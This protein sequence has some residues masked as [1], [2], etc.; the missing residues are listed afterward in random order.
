VSPTPAKEDADREGFSSS[1]TGSAGATHTDRGG[2]Q[3]T[4][5]D[6]AGTMREDVNFSVSHITRYLT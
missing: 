6:V 4:M 1:G 3:G 5:G 2:P